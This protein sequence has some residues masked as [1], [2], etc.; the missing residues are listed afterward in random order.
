MINGIYCSSYDMRDERLGGRLARTSHHNLCRNGV[1]DMGEECDDGL[2]TA[3]CDVDCTLSLCGDHLVNQ[4][5]GEECDDGN[6]VTEACEYGLTECVVC[7][8]QCAEV[9]GALT[10]YCGDG[11]VNGPEVCDGTPSC[12]DDCMVIQAPCA[13][14]SQGCPE[15]DFVAIS[16]GVFMMGDQ[17][18]SPDANELPV[19]SVTVPDFELMR[20][21]ITVAMYR[22]CFDAEEC[23]E[24][25]T[26][27]Q[28]NWTA[29]AGLKEAHPINCVSWHQL[30]VFAAWVGARLP[31]E[32]EWE[33]AARSQGQN[34]LYPWGDEEP[35][36]SLANT[37]PCSASPTLSTFAV[38]SLP[39]GNT[40]QGICDMAG[41]V[42]NSLK[43]NGLRIIIARL[44]MGAVDVLERVLKMRMIQAMTRTKLEAV[45]IVMLNMLVPPLI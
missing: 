18:E 27:E 42:Q 20:T 3:L 45:F 25:S 31:T 1:I 19:H 6:T 9:P 33:Y 32:A 7:N 37:W 12:S 23:S 16:G 39:D 10:G 30:M 11:V 43:I 41:N 28:C 13:E 8:D 4:P 14:S 34:I 2:E 40:D 22:R 36:C 5:A 35:T 21:E 38:C 44:M 17:R 29:N 24:P 15:L 26:G